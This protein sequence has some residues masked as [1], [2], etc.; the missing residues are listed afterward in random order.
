[1]IKPTRIPLRIGL[2][3]LFL[4]VVTG[5][6]WAFSVD[7]GPVRNVRTIP[8]YRHSIEVLWDA[9]ANASEVRA[10]FINWQATDGTGLGSKMVPPDAPNMAQIQRLDPAKVYF[11]NIYP[12]DAG[13]NRGTPVTLTNIRA[14]G[15]Y[16]TELENS[17]LNGQQGFLFLPERD[18]PMM[19]TSITKLANDYQGGLQLSGN[20]GLERFQFT[21]V[22]NNRQDHWHQT[23]RQD[24]EGTM[25]SRLKAKVYLGDGG[26]RSLLFDNDTGPFGARA[27]YVIITPNKVDRFHLIP[28]GGEGGDDF[29][30]AFPIEQ[31]R[32]KVV[33]TDAKASRYSNGT[34]VA[35]V[36]F[37]WRQKTYI[38]ARQRLRMDINQRGITFLA[39]TDYTGTPQ[40]IGTFGTDMSGWDHVYIYFAM[41]MYVPLENS[42]GGY[43][44]L[45]TP[46]LQDALALFHWGN[47]AV[48]APAGNAP[49]TELSYYRDPDAVQR[50]RTRINPA[51]AFTINVD[52]L[53]ADVSERELIFTDATHW[54]ECDRPGNGM[55]QALSNPGTRVLVNGTVLSGKSQ[56]Q[57]RAEAPAY[58]YGIPPGV[59]VA[60]ANTVQ[61]VQTGTAIPL[62]IFS[63][64]IDVLVPPNSSMISSYTPPPVNDV[65]DMMPDDTLLRGWAIPSV[66]F[67]PPQMS[68]GVI[69]LPYVADAA[70]TLIT[71]GGLIGMSS[72]T[73]T[74]DGTPFWT[75]YIN[76]EGIGTPYTSG[77]LTL[78]T[79]LYPDGYHRVMFSA[80]T[81]AGAVGVGNGA[82][83]DMTE[84]DFDFNHSVLFYNGPAVTTPPTIENVRVD[85]LNNNTTLATQAIASGGTQLVRSDR[86]FRMQFDAVTEG[87][88]QEAALYYQN[89]TGVW[90]RTDMEKAGSLEISDG[91]FD[92]GAGTLTPEN[93]RNRLTLSWMYEVPAAHEEPFVFTDPDGP[94]IHYKLVVTN[95]GQFTVEYPFTYKL[96]DPDM[97]YFEQVSVPAQIQINQP[98]NASFVIRNIGT[99]PWEAN[100]NHVLGQFNEEFPLLFGEDGLPL[101]NAV[102]PGQTITLQANIAQMM[103]SAMMTFH[104]EIRTLNPDFEVFASTEIRT[105]I[106]TG[107]NSQ[108]VSQT[109]P[110]TMDPNLPYNVSVTMR[111]TGT[112]T[113]TPAGGYFL[114]GDNPAHNVLW[115]VPQVPL[116]ANES[117]PPGASKTFDFTVYSPGFPNVYNFQWRMSQMTDNYGEM[118]GARSAN[119]QVTVGNPQPILP[120]F[121]TQPTDQHIQ[122][123][124]TATFWASVV[125]TPPPGYQWQVRAASSP[126]NPN[127]T[128]SPIVGATGNSITTSSATLADDGM[129]FV[130]VATNTAGSVN[131][132][133]ATLH[134]STGAPSLIGELALYSMSITNSVTA[135]GLNFLPRNVNLSVNKSSGTAA[136][137][138]R[139]LI[140]KGNNFL[141]LTQSALLDPSQSTTP[142]IDMT[143][144][145]NIAHNDLLNFALYVVEADGTTLR[146]FVN[147][148]YTVLI[149]APN[150]PN[151][152]FLPETASNLARIGAQSLFADRAIGRVDFTLTR[153]AVSGS[154][155]S[156]LGAPAIAAQTVGAGAQLLDLGRMPLSNGP[157]GVSAVATDWVGNVSAPSQGAIFIVGDNLS[158]VLPYPNP[159]HTRKHA[160]MP[161]TFGNLTAQ[162]QVKIFTVSGHW[163]KSIDAVGGLATWDLTNDAGQNVASGL[164]I[165]VVT[166]NAGDRAR[167]QIAVV[168]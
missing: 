90:V 154:G 134:V 84:S 20:P 16:E 148:M 3:A 5:F 39:D 128:F 146:T 30:F 1:M 133:V 10:Y 22:A 64:H 118:F 66:D 89:A 52:A 25:T 15:T 132:F 155:N 102:Q 126:A 168:R 98:M 115:S 38:N 141:P 53:S 131:S 162:A 73:A 127:P 79:T 159:W 145:T 86:H 99:T 36:P 78:D 140:G 144:V 149:N 122:P 103:P 11:L 60:G 104:P 158:N 74:I 17:T 35:E 107:N 96:R 94:G 111:N 51:N 58:R 88:V 47:V 112:T 57:L 61:I 138:V 77:A 21:S 2:T 13:G 135:N 75:Q 23:G 119:V 143:T 160:G 8:A 100:G 42:R 151:L 164:Y 85:E 95:V 50:A 113:W 97:A 123:G 157:Y 91:R 9:P 81:L 82:R 156:A 43:N 54:P 161:M 37:N 76:P 6:S 45:G 136:V 68:S 105:A 49:Q 44:Y 150:P 48:T 4:A 63:P 110:T 93:G 130:L 33:H 167:G 87:F 32:V 24:G 152:G 142:S 28:R 59:L 153:R 31:V 70:H 69:Q 29:A 56:A 137:D 72:F 163:V 92:L 7:P 109:V 62:S 165:Y 34:K 65:T 166:N 80:R 124:Q 26:T 129:Q 106:V 114:V 55:L 83:T 19:R 12:V 139:L 27:W 14:Q 121:I 147:P 116:D 67:H 46:I 101:P 125:G 117:I 120:S 40:V 41:G 71:S 18:L 108:Y